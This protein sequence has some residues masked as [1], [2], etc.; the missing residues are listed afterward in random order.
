[1]QKTYCLESF[2]ELVN[3]AIGNAANNTI[4]LVKD[5]LTFYHDFIRPT[6]RNTI[7]HYI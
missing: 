5:E 3:C 2:Y 7:S 4:I 6:V 1:M